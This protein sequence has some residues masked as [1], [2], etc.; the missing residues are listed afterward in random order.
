MRDPTETS[1]IHSEVQNQKWGGSDGRQEVGWDGANPTH[2]NETTPLPPS[3]HATKRRPGWR[4][5]VGQGRSVKLARS[6]RHPHIWMPV[7]GVRVNAAEKRPSKV[8]PPVVTRMSP[9][10]LEDTELVPPLG[11]SQWPSRPSVRFPA[12]VWFLAAALPVRV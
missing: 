3:P 10:T 8:P 1:S 6:D 9:R 4:A 11:F 5:A 12:R 2:P 7:G